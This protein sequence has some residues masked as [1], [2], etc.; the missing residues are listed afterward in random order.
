MNFETS[1]ETVWECHHTKKDDE[2]A[3]AAKEA[4]KDEEAEQILECCAYGWRSFVPDRGRYPHHRTGAPPSLPHNRGPRSS[5][6]V[7]VR[8]A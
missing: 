6:Y 7:A 1:A 2:D 8:W 4:S 3:P 5:G